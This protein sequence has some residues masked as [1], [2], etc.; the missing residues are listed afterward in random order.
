MSL[1]LADGDIVVVTQKIV[2]KSEGGWSGSSEVKP[3]RRAAALAAELGKDPRVVELVLRES[4]RV[5]RKGHGVLI[6][7]TRHGFVCAN[8]GHRH[9]E[10]GVSGYV[11]LLPLDPDASARRIQETPGE[12]D[13]EEARRDSD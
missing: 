5:V 1:E 11:A 3:T 4:R 9:V 13:R 2:S 12:G 6:T 10:R 8:S 7:E